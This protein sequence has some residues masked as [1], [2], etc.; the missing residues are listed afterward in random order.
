M[1]HADLM[2]SMSDQLSTDQARRVLAFC[3]LGVAGFA[4]SCWSNLVWIFTAGRSGAL[5]C[6]QTVK[7]AV[8]ATTVVLLSL[9]TVYAQGKGNGYHYIP[10]RWALP[11]LG[12]TLLGAALPFPRS[13][14]P[15]RRPR[16][17][18]AVVSVAAAMAFLGTYLD[19]WT[20]ADVGALRDPFD[21]GLARSLKADE[22]FVV[23]GFG[24]ATGLLC[25]AQ[26]RSPMPFVDS[27]IVY[28]GMPNDYPLRREYVDAWKKA[29]AA[30]NVRYF[31]VERDEVLWPWLRFDEHDEVRSQDVVAK[32]FPESEL[33]ALGFQRSATVS[34]GGVDVYERVPSR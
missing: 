34:K 19:G 1:V 9:A 14:W 13:V 16:N 7:R 26:R 29:M 11:M 33:A 17:G 25:A 3:A 20:H 18:I 23:F 15:F 21:D 2:K 5:E 28:A 27:W 32:L 22:T 24:A 10:V 8:G 4:L 31:L 6:G 30:P 12:A